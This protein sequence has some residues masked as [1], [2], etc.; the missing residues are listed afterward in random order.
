MTVTIPPAVVD[1]FGEIERLTAPYVGARITREVMHA[2]HVH[3]RRVL[4]DAANSLGSPALYG[5][6]YYAVV[7]RCPHGVL[8]T[9]LKVNT[10]RGLKFL[11]SVGF[12]R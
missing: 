4:M 6:D 12:E 1:V 7:R 2:V 5:I 11:T 10:A 8:G 9:D 3:V